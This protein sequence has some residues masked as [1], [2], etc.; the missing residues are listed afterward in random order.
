LGRS[1]PTDGA[2]RRAHSAAALAVQ[3]GEGGLEIAD[4]GAEV[5]LGRAPQKPD[6]G[7]DALLLV[8]A[9]DLGDVALDRVLEGEEQATE[10]AG[11]DVEQVA[12]A[13]QTAGS[14]ATSTPA[15]AMD[16]INR[17][18]E[19]NISPLCRPPPVSSR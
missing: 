6:E 13:D 19:P 8:V 9:E 5:L 17:S 2:R 15:M 16:V 18:P 7:V 1:R 14:T 3:A 4:Q 12:G 10:L 11:T